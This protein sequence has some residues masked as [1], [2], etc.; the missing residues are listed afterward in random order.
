MNPDPHA[1][2]V[3]TAPAD[4]LLDLVGDALDLSPGE[5]AAFL[6][7]ACQGD[8]ALLAEALSLVEHGQGTGE[9]LG[10]PAYAL[11]GG[12][13]L[14]G[15]E[16]GSLQPGDELGDCRVIS[17]LGEGGMGEVYLAEDTRLERRVA[18]K[19]L[20]R[21]L[22]D[23]SLVRRFRHERRVLAALTHP[24]IAR[25]Y[26]GGT[27]PEGRSYLV[28]EY[29]EGERLD[30]YGATR[31]L[32]ITERLALFRK[33]CAAVSYA[34]QNLV[35]HRDLKPAN[36]RVTP[37]G[38]PKLLDF[39]IAK[40]LDPEGDAASTDADPTAT[41][42]GAMTPEY[43]S[44]EQLRGETITTVSDVY[45]LGVVLYELLCGQRP[46]TLKN[47]R[48]DELARA[49]CEQDPP[50]LSTAAS[51]TAPTT[52]T[53]TVPAGQ[54][55]PVTREPAARLRRLLEGDLDNI[56]AKALRK[57]PTRRYPSV[58]ALSEDIRRHCEGLPV[59]A[60]KDTLG[61]RAGKFV[62]RNK[63]GVATAAAIV[64]TLVGGLVAT[65]W[66]ARVAEKERDRARAAQTRAETAQRQS[67]LAR[68]QAERLNGFLQ[69]LLGSA[70]P[71]NGPGRDLKVIRVLDQASEQLDRELAGEP[72]LRAQ[73][74]QTIGY[75]YF[76]LKE[77]EPALRHVR[78]A[79][80]INRQLYGDNAL[81]TARSKAALGAGILYLQRDLTGAEPLLREALEVE[82]RQGLAEQTSLPTIL[83]ALARILTVTGRLDQADSMIQEALASARR[84]SGE[85]SEA[86]A[87]ALE[88]LG[89]LYMN[90]NDYVS[91][92]AALRQALA[93]Y[94]GLFPENSTWARLEGSVAY[95]L[96]L[97][98]KADEAG[99]MLHES[100]DILRRI[101]GEDSNTYHFQTGLLAL[102][103]FEKGDYAAAERE[104]RYAGDYLFPRYP[105]D[106]E[107][108]VGCRVVLGVSLTHLNRPA[109][110]EPFLREALELSRANRFT[111]LMTSPAFTRS[112]LIE[113][114]VAEKNYAAAEPFLLEQSGEV[115]RKYG[116]HDP[117]TSAVAKKLH[118][119]Y[120]AWNKPEQA[121]QYVPAPPAA[122]P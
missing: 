86:Y 24:N 1:V 116:A 97:Q 65:I 6:A 120:A 87:R 115:T 57:E 56:V 39:G 26:G 67:D 61:Y 3:T 22:D 90:K 54:E 91:S 113:C 68:K 34:H 75:A 23:A 51:R 117:H 103:H 111:G 38:E 83:N 85:K 11:A 60:R 84:T 47:R 93:I 52:V 4:R 36:I 35:V 121:A 9:F 20:K 89:T 33:V 5:R 106:D 82:R 40:L 15:L 10:R 72:D 104:M 28:M 118:D 105:K 73:A 71:E 114:L 99:D 25:L 7:E 37:E 49:I 48:P 112:S 96:L 55:V 31:K 122:L 94:K 14:G 16:T 119:F 69:T 30:R 46:Y 88:S 45:S 77:A 12:E 42:L 70:N 63:A 59:T 95:V 43:A 107:D 19:L 109:E 58:L 44:P 81:A 102:M 101:V 110:G 108:M 17:L 66:Q 29:V 76:G 8:A 41:L 79:L 50:R 27:T 78:T 21:R 53:A 2:P 100:M 64:L 32:G 74:H 13:D 62:R 80:A 98:G 18:V 92:V